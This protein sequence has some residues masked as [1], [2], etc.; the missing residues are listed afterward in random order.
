MLSVALLV[1]VALLLGWFLRGDLAEYEAFKL[2]TRTEDRQ[3]A[4]RRWTIKSFFLFGGAALAVLAIVGRLDALVRMPPEFASLSG[5]IA[6]RF[7]G[8]GGVGTGFL[9]G[10]GVAAVAGGMIGLVA[11]RRR[12]KGAPPASPA[13]LGDIQP[14]FPRNAQE[15]RWTALMAANAGPGEELLF[16][17]AV[18]LLLVQAIGDAWLSFAVAAI[19]FGLVHLY[20][21][22]LG[23]LVTTLAGAAFTALYLATGSIWIAAL[24]HSLMNLNSLWLQPLLRDALAARR[25]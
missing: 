25:G 2:L 17:L 19:A 6:A 4:F 21:G 1:G 5:P 11:S 20:Q 10:L 3:R 7:S 12:T 16:R 22:W 23:V 18:P 14:L 9:I 8:E 15:R 24:V 13:A